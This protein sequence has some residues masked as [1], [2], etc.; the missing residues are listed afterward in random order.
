MFSVSASTESDLVVKIIFVL[1]SISETTRD[2]S[3]ALFTITVYSQFTGHILS[4]FPLFETKEKGN[5]TNLH[6]LC[7]EGNKSLRVSFPS[8]SL[9]RRYVEWY[10]AF[11]AATGKPKIN[12]ERFV[13]CIG[14]DITEDRIEVDPRNLLQSP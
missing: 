8:P 7:K 5:F 13:L 1:P 2:I 4:I 14:I 12:V 3:K 6:L 9:C 11:D 10:L